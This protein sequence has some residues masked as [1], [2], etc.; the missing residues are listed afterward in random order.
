M[1]ANLPA[2]SRTPTRAKTCAT[3]SAAPRAAA[4]R[5]R[6]LAVARD[7]YMRLGFSAVTMH[8]TAAA[9][10]VSK[11]TLYQHFPSKDELLMAVT[12]AH[13]ESIHGALREIYRDASVTPLRRL[14][15]M[16]DFLAGM[17]GELSGAMAHDMQRCAPECWREVESSRQRSIEGDFST[18]LR[19]GRAKG[20][21]RKDVEPRIFLLIYAEVAKHV[22]NPETFSRLA[23][24]PARLFEAV[25]KVLFEGILTEKARKESH[26]AP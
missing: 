18:L 9:A 23:I 25:C 15:R 3:R 16:M 8:E 11:K 5:R 22:L 24:A 2:I 20:Y 1:T 17:F 19:E 26:D 7:Q 10:G 21:F 12:R 4:M 13:V 14:R 6:L